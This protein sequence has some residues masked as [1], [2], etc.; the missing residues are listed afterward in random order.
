MKV[1][2]ELV[3]QITKPREGFSGV[4]YADPGHGAAIPTIGYGHTRGVKLGDKCTKD[5]AEKWLYED[6]AIAEA[7]VLKYISV[8]LKQHEFDALVDFVFNIG[9]AKFATSTLRFKLNMGDSSAAD[10]FLK[11]VY[12]N[13]IKLKGL[14]IRR[15]MER[16]WFLKGEL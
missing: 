5:Q 9:G 4:A 3:D 12:S 2:K 1:S 13:K 10:E 15:K 16:D 8:P 14:E 6:L 7:E 11:W